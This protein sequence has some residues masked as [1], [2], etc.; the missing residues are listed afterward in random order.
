LGAFKQILGSQFKVDPIDLSSKSGLTKSEG[1]VVV[2]DNR[3]KV[4]TDDEVRQLNGYLKNGGKAVF[5]VDGVWV[6]DDVSGAA[7]ATHNLFKLLKDWG[8]TLNQDLVL[9]ESAQV[10]PFGSGQLQF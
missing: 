8:I 9:S 3:T 10:V 7:P 2:L 1:A 5:F 6:A 4:Y